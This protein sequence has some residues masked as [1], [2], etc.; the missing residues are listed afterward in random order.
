MENKEDLLRIERWAGIGLGLG[1]LSLVAVLVSH[2]ALTDIYH[3]EGDLTLEWNV[4]RACFAIIVA[5]QVFTL[6]ALGK[7]LRNA[8]HP[9]GSLG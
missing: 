1:A 4:L 3:A 5:V 9:A 7:V 6:L 8:R 2:L